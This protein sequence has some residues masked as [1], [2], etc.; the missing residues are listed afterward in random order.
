MSIIP[1]DKWLLDASRKPLD[2]FEKLRDYFDG[3]YAFEI[4]EHLILHG[5]YHPTQNGKKRV[6]I[7]KENKVWEITDQEIEKLQ[8]LWEGPDVPVFIFPSDTTNPILKIDF[9]GKSGLAYKNKLFLFISEDNSEME[10]RSLITHEYNHVCRLSKYQKEEEEYSLLDTII[11]EG[12]AEHAVFERFGKDYLSSWTST[13]TNNELDNIW[14][15]HIYPHRNILKID[16]KHNDLLYGGYK[17]PKMSGYCA[18]YYLVKKY[19]E[20]NHLTPKE[21]LNISSAKIAQI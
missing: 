2:I 3:A 16:P 15:K 9:N 1:T 10:I 5:M 13:Y 12:L 11:L 20:S 19:M 17:Y 18:G 8:K 14:N 21:M 6:K 4:F 7:L